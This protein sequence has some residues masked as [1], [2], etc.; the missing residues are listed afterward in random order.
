LKV[1]M[2]ETATTMLSGL[3]WNQYSQLDAFAAVSRLALVL[4][5]YQPSRRIRYSGFSAL[6]T[7]PQSFGDYVDHQIANADDWKI[8]YP[9]AFDHLAEPVT[10]RI[11]LDKRFLL[12]IMRTESFY[13]R[14]ARSPVGAVGLMQIMP[15]TAL[16][17]ARL[18]DDEGFEVESLAEPQTS[19]TYGA[20]YLD[21]LLRHYG[22]NPYVAAAAYNGGPAA[23]NSWLD[24]CTDC[25]ADEFVESIAYRETRRYVRQVM[26]SF[27]Q[28][29]RIYDGKRTLPELPK[30][31]VHLP[32]GEEM[33]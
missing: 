4:D 16:K 11:G 32:E 14:E 33:F 7:L 8:Y 20:Y 1:G 28:Y 29:A 26:T 31:P 13:N 10:S 30:L 17:I 18:L 2:K 22:G 15:Y 6:R 19:I 23:T 5:D 24:A 21:R 3:Q 25:A 27:A 12:S 9:Q